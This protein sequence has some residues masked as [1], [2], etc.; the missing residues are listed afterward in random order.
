MSDGWAI[1]ILVLLLA[2]NA[3]FVGAE[4]ALISAKRATIEPLAAAGNRRARVTLKAIADVSTMM[5]GAQ[6]GITACSLGIG[7]IGEPAVAHL[8]EP[9]MEALG[10]PEAWVHPIAFII[11][12]TIVVGLHM[13]LGE[14]VPKNIAIAGPDRSALVL[15]P[16]LLA[17]VTALRPI[18]SLLNGSANLVL[19]AFGVNPSD[20][21]AST[22]NREQV[23]NLI[24]ESQRGGMLEDEEADLLGGAL[25]LGERT[26][27][28]VLIPDQALRCLPGSATCADVERAVA[29]TGYSRFPLVDEDA[30]P[31]SYVHV[32]DVLRDPYEDAATPIPPGAKRVLPDVDSDA[33]LERVVRRLQSAGAHLGR[34]VEGGA[35]L[36]VIALEDALEEFIGEISDTAHRA[37]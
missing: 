23:A 12:M 6:L 13:V 3:F 35:V 25:E 34:V 29:D 9:G 10:I 21:V 17:V 36:G 1:A 14:M 31:I 37:P 2:G 8:I 27:A 22:Y 20:E 7:A 15:G 11:A 18:I 16:A 24:Q 4:F 5:A 19:R 28:D 33:S 32:K 26:A 30:V